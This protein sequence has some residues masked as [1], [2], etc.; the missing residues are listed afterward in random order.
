M[1]ASNWLPVRF[2]L[3]AVL[4]FILLVP[5]GVKAQKNSVRGKV[6]DD[7]NRP[8][9]GVEVLLELLGGDTRQLK[10]ATRATGHF[11][12]GGLSDGKYQ[13]TYRKEGYQSVAWEVTLPVARSEG[14]YGARAGL[15]FRKNWESTRDLD[16]GRVILPKLRVSREAQKHFDVGLE[17]ANVE[18]YQAAIDSFQ[19]FVELV[20]DSAEAYFNIAIAYHKIGDLE[21]PLPNLKK[22][23]ELRSDYYEAYVKLGE[24]YSSKR[25]WREAMEAVKKAVELRP[26]DV[27]ALF[28]YGAYANN[29]GDLE[30][31]QQAFETLLELEPRHAAANHHLGM[32]LVGQAKNEEAAVLLETYL[33]LEPEGRNATTARAILEHLKKN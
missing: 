8:L 20:P 2:L 16:F 11:L 4:S 14:E 31:A 23:I 15:N 5:A 10:T 33:E 29:G 24:V 21:K 9:E 30:A 25:Q 13:I 6:F 19:K 18:N 28:N 3:L 17:M 7:Q 27:L 26:T 22:A 12:Q 1:K 32:I